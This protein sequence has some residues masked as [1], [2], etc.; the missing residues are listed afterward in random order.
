MNSITTT[1]VHRIRELA[2]ELD[3]LDRSA[4]DKA[5]EAG[6]LLTEC[7]AGLDHGAW[8]PWLGANFTFTDR[9]ASNWMRIARELDSG[10]LKS[11]SVSDLGLTEA[12]RLLSDR[13]EDTEDTEDTEPEPLVVDESKAETLKPTPRPHV[14]QNS[15]EHE[16]FT[17]PDF[18]TSAV[19]VMG[20]I[21]LD[22]ASCTA[23]NKTVGAKR[24]HTKEKDGL[25]HNWKGRVWMNPPY[26]QPLC[27]KFC[28]KLCAS[29][30]TGVSQAI[31]LVNNGTETQWF[32]AMAE[33]ATAI[34]FPQGRIKFIDP[35]GKPGAPLQGQAILYFG[36]H[37]AK[38]AAEFAQYGLILIPDRKEI[39]Q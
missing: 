8:L 9:T 30:A 3:Q 20:C 31:A 14:S 28:I 13:A 6:R 17:P 34:C 25:E 11:E 35:E 29:L 26:A 23:A 1:T 16:W 4:L 24:I 38:F 10:R 21:D 27:E 36:L 15:G 7:K 39:A 19:V 32:Q 33:S 37:A 2:S 5:A 22:P 18:I 12:Y